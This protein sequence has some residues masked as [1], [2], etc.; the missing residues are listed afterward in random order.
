MEYQ[1]E[2]GQKVRVLSQKEKPVVTIT[3]RI[4]GAALND[5]YHENLYE[6]TGFLHKQ[7]ERVLEAV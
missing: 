3:G 4:P 7:R 6:V 5:P 2:I 1:F